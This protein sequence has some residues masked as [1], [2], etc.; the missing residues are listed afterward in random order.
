VRQKHNETKAYNKFTTFRHIKVFYSLLYDLSMLGL[1]H[2]AVHLLCA[3]RFID[4]QSL[5][6][7]NLLRNKSVINP[8][9][10]RLVWRASVV[11]DRV[12]KSHSQ[13]QWLRS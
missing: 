5:Q 1:M 12:N 9:K 13:T 7:Y 3:F 11:R 10:R 8:T 2:L 4:D 6:I